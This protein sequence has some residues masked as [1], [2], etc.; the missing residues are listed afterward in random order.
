MRH[1][2]NKTKLFI[3]GP[4]QIKDD[5]TS[6]EY[7]AP[8][9][10]RDSEAH[11]LYLSIST[12]LF[13]LAGV[14]EDDYHCILMNGSGTNGME[15]CARSLVP[16]DNSVTFLSV[17]AF[18]DL[19]ST[20]ARAAGKESH[21]RVE[22]E[23]GH[24]VTLS[25]FDRKEIAGARTLVLTH[26]ESSTGVVNDIDS[27][28]CWSRERGVEVILDGVSIF[29]GAPVNL[30]KNKPL[31]YV[32][33][34]QK[35]LGLPAGIGIV[36]LRKDGVAERFECI[37]NRGYT[38]DLKRHVA[39]AEKMEVLTT[40]NCT[41]WRQLNRQLQHIVTIEGVHARF[42]RHR[43]LR[44]QVQEWIERNRLALF[45]EP[46]DASPTLSAIRI[47]PNVNL[48]IL[49][50]K[51]RSRGFLMDTG[52][53]KVNQYLMENRGYQTFRIPHMADMT[54][55]KLRDFLNVVKQEMDDL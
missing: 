54:T 17:G 41:L 45:P 39:A 27:I 14:E 8:F 38:T 48:K 43:A 22:F 40:P 30:S 16:N 46:K 6:T 18:G 11:D 52:Y 49:K 25:S 2:L 33:S 7:H 19:F 34:T 28:C 36:F 42:D 15:A 50:E 53:A 13:R 12:N 10:H 1:K 4:V 21:K 51:V 9:G 5:L 35:C 31:A 23:L 20:I 55:A 44:A 47:S 26:N 29:G 32:T 24:A 37:E 3:P